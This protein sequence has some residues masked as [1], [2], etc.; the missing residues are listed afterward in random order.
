[1]T[2]Q[3]LGLVAAYLLGAVP[4]AYLVARARGVDIRTVGSGNVGATNVFRA[5]GKGAGVL[6]FLLDAAKGYAAAAGLPP[7]LTA[8]GVPADQ[9]WPL[10]GALG[11]LAAV[12]GHNWPVY[13]GFKGGKGVATSAGMLLGIAPAAMGLGFG[14]WIV[15]F[16]ASRYV[17]VASIAAA[18]VV[19]AAGWVWRAPGAPLL[20][21]FLTV[22]GA[23]TLVRHRSNLQRL[24]AGTENRFQFGKRAS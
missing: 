23:L 22:I 4:F 24:R 12:C 8:L 20:P 7:A 13:L 11:G 1:M 16:L 17:S 5:V 19:V 18:L 14:A 6:T 10:Y 21:A 2:A 9:H 15:V 3:L